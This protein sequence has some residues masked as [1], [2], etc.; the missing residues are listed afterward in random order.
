MIRRIM[1]C[2]T[3]GKQVDLPLDISLSQYYHGMPDS[4]L[5]LVEGNPQEHTALHFCS[6]SHVYQ[7]ASNRLRESESKT[8]APTERDSVNTMS[9]TS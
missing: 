9:S 8:T 1:Q 4:W 3:C 2:E 6:L 5:T 7:W